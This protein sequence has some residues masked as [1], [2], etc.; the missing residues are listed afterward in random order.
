MSDNVRVAVRV[1]PFNQRERERQ[2]KNVIRI[3]G[4]STFIA[5]PET[6]VEKQFS[7]DYSYD[8]FGDASDPAYASQARVYGERVRTDGWARALGYKR[9]Q[10]QLRAAHRPPPPPLPSPGRRARKGAGGAALPHE[11]RAAAAAADL[12]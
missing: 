11:S 4:S 6:G 7:F 8:S 9:Q 3:E 12:P 5:H 2:A 10:Q 1:R